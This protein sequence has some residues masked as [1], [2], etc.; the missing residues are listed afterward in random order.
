MYVGL[1]D[2]VSG[3]AANGSDF[4]LFLKALKDDQGNQL[5]STEAINAIPI[6]GSAITVITVWV[7]S[8]L[9]D[10]FQKRWLIVFIQA[11]WGIIPCIIMSIWEVPLGAKYFS[12][13]SCFPPDLSP[14]A[15]I[16]RLRMLPLFG[17][18]TFHL[19]LDV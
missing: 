19:C 9:S 4:N 5:W 12:C 1:E 18:C 2:V 8:F 15:D 14:A 13:E 10:Y 16:H 11:A 7:Y 6:A 17:Y 3:P